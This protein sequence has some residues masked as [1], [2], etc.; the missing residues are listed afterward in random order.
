[1]HTIKTSLIIVVIITNTLVV[2]QNPIVPNK[3]L[4][5]PHI[6]IFDDIAYLYA[7]HDKSIENK[8]F[9][10]E[11]WWVWS[12]PD[13]VNWTRRS[14]LKPDNTYIG[15]SFQ[16]CWATD[17]GYKNGKYYWYFSEGNEQT[18]VVVGD[19]PVGPWN[20]P[21]GKP[22]LSSELTPT[23]EY[24]MAVFEEDNGEHYI[25]FGV[26]DYYVAKLNNDMISLAETPKKII[27]NNPR[28]PYNRDGNNKSMPTDDKP[29]V[30]KYNNKYYLSWGCFYA[31]SDNLYGPYDYVD[32][33][34]KESSFAKG[35]ANPTWPNG[36]LQGRHGSFFE[37]HNQWYFAYCDISQTNNRWFRDTFISYVHYKDNGEIATIRVDGVGVG[38]YD[39]NQGFI[40]AEDYF[41]ANGIQKTEN[42][43]GGFSI[44]SNEN[45]AFVVYP[46]IENLKAKSTIEFEV[47]SKTE[48]EVE[49]RDGSPTGKLLSTCKLPGN[50]TNAFINESFKINELYNGQTICLVFKSSANSNLKLN[51]FRFK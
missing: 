22:L 14:T 49:V 31:M 3:G 47:L 51:R 27:I 34:I 29:F 28:G 5:D 19:S 8:G 30:H 44:R 48:T 23:H 18:G 9:V 32:T 7:S 11:D 38:Q 45:S 17:V 40:E 6:H 4:N 41:K 10:M 15:K 24:D 1:M 16:S 36:F 21:L 46:N 26:W 20:D 33:I 50:T 12:S 25:F 13:L 35:Y 2:A 43:M 42:V 37:W 39:A